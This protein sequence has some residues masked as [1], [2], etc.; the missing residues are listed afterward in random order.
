MEVLNRC[1]GIEDMIKLDDLTEETL[2]QNLLIR[3]NSE[4]IY[5]IQNKK[6]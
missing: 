3:Y 4:I 5:V 1:V 2:L 6:N